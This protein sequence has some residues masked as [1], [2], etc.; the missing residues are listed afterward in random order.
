MTGAAASCSAQLDPEAMLRQAETITGHRP[1]FGIEAIAGLRNFVAS[2]RNEAALNRAGSARAEREIVEMLCERLR[3]EHC[4]AENPSI[5]D[6][7]IPPCIFVIGLP[8]TGSTALSQFLSEDPDARSIRRWELH[9][10]TPPPD[11]SVRADP[12][13]LATREEFARRE[14]EQ[15]ELK[16]ALPI[17][18]EDPSEHSII[19]NQTF[20]NAA[21]PVLYHVPGYARWLLGQ[22]LAPAYRHFAK[23]LKILQWKTPARHWNLKN[24]PDIFSL[25]AIAEIFPEAVFVWTHRD[26]RSSM[27]SVA[28]LAALHRHQ[29]SDRVDRS[30]LM[31]DMLGYWSEGVRRA[32]AARGEIGEDR[33]IDFSQAQLAND[34]VGA[35][36][37]L[38][39]KMGRPFT[40]CYQ[41]HLEKR[42]SGRP[43][44][45]HGSHRYDASEFGVTAAQLGQPF[46]EYSARFGSLLA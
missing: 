27:A 46:S 10:P 2:L 15:P 3:V 24:P 32:M 34:P 1:A 38:Y 33:F 42:L 28:G 39:G 43:R 9:H 4:L 45:Q 40:A 5:L 44:G 31:G 29:V 30:G 17:E 18:A 13:L 8:R 12:R 23:V 41:S 6:E 22:D 25:E 19:L 21:L 16:A 36:R 26:P 7:R 37:S 11:Q 35:I 20:L 14:R